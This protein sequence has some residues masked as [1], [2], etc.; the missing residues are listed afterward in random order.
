MRWGAL[1]QATAETEKAPAPNNRGGVEVAA[2]SRPIT[3]PLVITVTTPQ[4]P[5]WLPGA[6]V[7]P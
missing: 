5:S 1:W 3:W 6:E 4:R 2:L 7:A